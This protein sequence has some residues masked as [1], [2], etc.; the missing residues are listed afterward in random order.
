MQNHLTI[1]HYFLPIIGLCLLKELYMKKYRTVTIFKNIRSCTL[2]Y[3]EK[4]VGKHA[5]MHN[6]S[7][8]II[9]PQP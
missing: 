6:R 2:Y 7:E 4:L 9:Q 8:S 3:A 1:K 5:T